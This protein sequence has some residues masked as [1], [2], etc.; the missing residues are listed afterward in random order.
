MFFDEVRSAARA[1]SR[2]RAVTAVLLVSLGVGTGA[3]AAVFGVVDA[4][5][6]RAPN[7]VTAPARLITLYTSQ[8]D[9][10]AFGMTSWP[11]FESVLRAGLPL[12]DLAALDDRTQANAVVGSYAQSTRIA[13]VT[14]NFFATIG[15]TARAGRLLQPGDA[16]EPSGPAVISSSLWEAAGRPE[17][18]ATR[19]AIAGREHTVVGVTPARFRGLQAGRSS[20][21]WIPLMPESNAVG[22]GDRR[23]SVVARLKRG[24]T[25]DAAGAL[26]E[27]LSDQL[28]DQYPSTNRGTQ[29]QPE[30]AR[31]LSALAYSSLQPEARRQ[32]SVIAAVVAGAVGLLLISACLNAGSLLL[33]RGFARR[34]ELAVKMALGATRERLVRQLLIE[35]LLISLG[36]AALGLLFANW[37]M[38][39][40]PALFSPDHAAMLD[41]TLQ[42]MLIGATILVACGAGAL[43]AVAPA[44]QATSSPAS[45]ALR[46]DSGGIS[47]QQGGRRLRTVLVAAQVAL[48]TVLLLAAGLLITG[49]K[50]VLNAD[51]NFPARNIAMVAMENPGRFVDPMRGLAYQKTLVETLRKR[52]EVHTVGWSTIAPLISPTRYEFRIEA[53]AADVTDAVELEVNVVSP[54][55]FDALGVRLVEGRLFDATDQTLSAP[56]AIV[57][58]PLARR[59]FGSAA[60]GQHLLDADGTRYEIVGVVRSRRFRTLQDAPRATVYYP[61]SQH[62][63]AQGNLFVVTRGD[64]TPLVAALPEIM[65]RIDTAVRI[66]RFVTLDRHLAEAL[67]IDR[68]TTTLVGVCG[69]MA[70]LMAVIGVYGVMNDAVQRRTREIG[71]RVAL[72]AARSQVAKLVFIEAV[73]VS[74][75]G[76]VAGTVIALVAVR[77]GGVFVSGVPAWGLK[78]LGAPPILLALIVVFAAVL[79]LRRALAVSASIAL[80]AE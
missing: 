41:T 46:A 66:T 34:R 13:A 37:T 61:V 16:R 52:K 76:L 26:L 4:L 27:R 3:N 70:L 72:G 60:A 21:V 79:P 36:G 9:G 65:T 6:F 22:R 14:E 54:T 23:L 69:V 42:P 12:D 75:A 78:T 48:S 25:L 57:D 64:A 15:M 10:S 53:G 24:A 51:R 11:D 38:Q 62:Y 2:A 56:V 28:A 74:I 49:F 29:A 45:T 8:Y 63:V 59:F 67:A 17:V 35:S 43:F 73:H 77:V 1:V 39:T 5:L 80:R 58:E 19:I 20:D 68:L 40:I 55:Y 18:G 31:R 32:A 30:K 71:L 33:A 44:L 7:G 50:D 47:E